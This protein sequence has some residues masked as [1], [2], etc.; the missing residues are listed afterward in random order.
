MRKEENRSV[1]DM[2]TETLQQFFSSE[3]I[4]DVPNHFI[5]LLTV[6]YGAVSLSAIIGNGIV[7]WFVV[8]SKKLRTVTNLFIA[9]LA[10]ADILI[11]ALAIP[12]QFQAALLQK[13]VLPHFMCAFCPF[14]QIVSVNVS[15]FTLTAIAADRYLVVIH[16]L[17]RRITKEKARLLIVIIWT[18]AIIAAIPVV[19]AMRVKMIIPALETLDENLIQIMIN[20]SQALKSNFSIPMKPYCDNFVIEKQLWTSY[21]LSL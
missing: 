5:A 10:I 8:R 1:S 11:G 2:D 9:N 15:I 3:A 12:F 14:I 19:I 18:V 20:A 17:N 6:A 13:W 21:H 4:Y 7:L 16:P